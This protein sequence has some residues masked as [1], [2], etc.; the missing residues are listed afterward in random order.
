M[1]SDPFL[2]S[3]YA[4]PIKITSIKPIV[5]TAFVLVLLYNTSKLLSLHNNDCLRQF[6]FPPAWTGP[7]SI[8]SYAKQSISS[9]RVVECWSASRH[10][11]MKRPLPHSSCPQ[12]WSIVVVR[13]EAGP[14]H[15]S[16]VLLPPHY[17]SHPT[18]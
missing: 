11:I 4:S 7:R 16:I 12:S 9:S 2:L 6:L 14:T 3:P 5:E 8:N 18:K 1:G 13:P 15:Q 17:H 10:V